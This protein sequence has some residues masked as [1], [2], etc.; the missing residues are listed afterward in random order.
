MPP[1][2]Y[3][4]QQDAIGRMHN[5]CI[6]CGGVGSGKSMTGL[7]YYYYRVSNSHPKIPLYI[8]TTAHKRDSMEWEFEANKW[9]IPFLFDDLTFVIDSWNNIEKY[10]DVKDAMFIF[11]EH[12]AIGNG[13]WAKCFLKIS[14][15]N[16][17]VI[18]TATPGDNWMDYV[19]VFV[20]NH[21]YRNRTDFIRQH[22][23][24]NP[25][26]TYFSVKNYVN[27]EKLIE[28][29]NKILVEMPFQK[30]AVK[31]EIQQIC[32]YNTEKYDVIFKNR[33]NFY[34]EEPIKNASEMCY[35]LRKVCNSSPDRV[36]KLLDILKTHD[37]VIIFYSYDYELDILKS[38]II[39]RTLTEWNGHSHDPISHDGKWAH[40]VQYAAGAEG[41][42][43]VETDTIIFY[44]LSYSYKQM[45]QAAGRIDRL[46]TPFETLYYYRLTSDSDI[47]K[48][49]RLALQTKKEFNANKFVQGVIW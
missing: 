44:S 6:L 29:R 28:F 19:P 17:W 15:Q 4:H 46:N 49:I 24:V 27:V 3:P 1:V 40:L 10:A 20:A 45:E 11:D 22:V 13:K 12:K 35:L 36:V 37:K 14:Q 43:C 32:E 39:D 48:A 16:R 26:V 18:L 47:D 2:L 38:A 42:N 33:W 41:W 30:I 21:F 8:I 9:G 25:Y 31:E 34:E 7:G 5:G 23:V